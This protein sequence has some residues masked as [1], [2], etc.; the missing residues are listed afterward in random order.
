MWTMAAAGVTGSGLLEWSPG[1]PQ[2]AAVHVRAEAEAAAGDDVRIREPGRSR[3]CLPIRRAG[4]C[5]QG[6]EPRVVSGHVLPPE[7]ERIGA[8]GVGQLIDRLLGRK[9]RPSVH[10]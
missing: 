5:V 1:P 9:G 2:A 3:P 8:G 6:C 7:L 10:R 4:Y